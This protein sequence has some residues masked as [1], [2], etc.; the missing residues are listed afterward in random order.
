MGLDA[1]FSEKDKIFSSK[2]ETTRDNNRLKLEI[3]QLKKNFQIYNQKCLEVVNHIK[4][5]GNNPDRF[6]NNFNLLR[7]IDCSFDGEK[8]V[9]F[10]KIG[11]R[12]DSL[13]AAEQGYGMGLDGYVGDDSEICRDS[14]GSVRMIVS[15]FDN[16]VNRFN[17]TFREGQEVKRQLEW[18]REKLASTV[19]LM[20][21]EVSG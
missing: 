4:S 11:L 21:G 3:A 6:L 14:K 20:G 10:G 18:T 2:E 15:E 13:T 19:K 5:V 1:S 8:K 17:G 16:F 12:D 7:G 9:D